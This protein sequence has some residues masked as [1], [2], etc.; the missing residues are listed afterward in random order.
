MENEFGK[1]LYYIIWIGL[2]FVKFILRKKYLIILK[3]KD[4]SFIGLEYFYRF[5]LNMFLLLLLYF[6]LPLRIFGIFGFFLNI[7]IFLV[8]T[9]KIILRKIE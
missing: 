5:N 6:I 7:I 1:W 3:Y 4:Y 8:F 2:L 9:T